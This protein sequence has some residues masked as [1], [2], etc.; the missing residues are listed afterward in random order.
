MAGM[1]VVGADGA[2]IGQVNDIQGDYIVVSKGLFFPTNFHVPRTAI[3]TVSDQV[4]LNVTRHD[5][6]NQ[7]WDARPADLL[8]ADAGDD[9]EPRPSD[10]TTP[11]NVPLHE[12]ELHASTREVERGRAQVKTVVTEHEEEF[13][14]PVNEEHVLVQRKTVSRDVEPGETVFTERTIEVPLRGEEVV[15]DKSV[16]VVE[17][18]EIDTEVVERTE[19]VTATARREDVQ[20]YDEDGN[21]VAGSDVQSGNPAQ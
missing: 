8:A 13:D 14:L 1:D 9:D 17:E 20:V 5:A 12:E 3:A 18:L 2:K 7:G 19:H 10:V 4:H 21:L 11:L 6:L 16:Q 15:I